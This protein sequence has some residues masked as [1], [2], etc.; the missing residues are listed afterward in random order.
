MLG[1]NAPYLIHAGMCHTW[2]YNNSKQRTMIS[3]ILLIF[4]ASCEVFLFIYLFIYFN[5][6]F[7]SPSCIVGTTLQWMK[8]WMKKL[9]IDV[10]YGICCVGYIDILQC[11]TSR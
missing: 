5:F 8:K 7:G 9:H 6:F 4:E 3:S 11:G 1:D 2:K 10:F